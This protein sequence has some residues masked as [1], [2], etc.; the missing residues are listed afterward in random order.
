MLSLITARV[1]DAR[2]RK[3]C[4]VDGGLDL[5][6][7]CR[8]L[9]QQGLTDSLVRDGDRLGIFTTADLRDA[10][11]RTEPP[12]ALAV[13]EVAQYG[14]IEIHPDAD[15]FEAL[16]LMV[17]H[18]VHRLLVRDGETVMGLLDELDL[19]S[20]LA[21]HSHIVALQIDQAA[22]VS[23][24]AAAA[25]RIDTMLALLHE[26][27][28]KIERIARLVGELNARL[29]A[30]LWSLLAPPDLVANSC[31][32]VM[33]SEGRGE[34]L[35]KTDQDNALLLRDGFACPALEAIAMQFNT[36]LAELGYPPCPGQIMLTNP[37]WRQPLT[38]FKDTL[39][40]WV[41][42]ADPKGPM[43]LAIF[44][45]SLAVAGDAR[46]LE[47]AHDHL[48]RIL[49][50]SDAFL[51]RFAGAIDL[52]DDASWWN[53]LTSRR[54][55][56]PIDLKKRGTFPIVH[57]VR[58]MALQLRLRVSGTAA[59][60]RLLVEQQQVDPDLARDVLDALHYLMA[61]KL[62]HQLHQ[63]QAGHVPGNLVRPSE[64]GALERDALHDALGVVRRFRGVLRQRFH[65]DA[66]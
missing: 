2:V 5:V 32:V 46:L 63:K 19:L 25:V 42:D 10:L 6:S 15:L 64:L 28:I 57:G 47:Q 23:E 65:L 36:A 56:Q 60:L 7:V 43:H 29:F 31:L 61:L 39:R 22:S 20:F 8:L 45:D 55:E 52:F 38:G 54:D 33:G 1:R 37:L 40:R 30:R 44:I 13:R 62:T 26:G 18:R 11:L 9:S 14:L 12:A 24:L 16:W 48:D 21:N 50:G 53:R 17:R 51:A 35:L 58:A 4:Y 66:L 34:Q 3:A 41:Y 49:G 59:R 27:G